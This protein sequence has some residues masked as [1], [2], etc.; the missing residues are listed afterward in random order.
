MNPLQL[1]KPQA[2]AQQPLGD[3][4]IMPEDN[5]CEPDAPESQLT[6]Q[7]VEALMFGDGPAAA[8]P[9]REL[10]ELDG[11]ALKYLA[12][13]LDDGHTFNPLFPFRLG[14]KYK[15][16]GKPKHQPDGGDL[17]SSEEN[18]IDA[19]MRGNRAKASA[20]LH[21]MKKLSGSAL[22]LVAQLLEDNPKLSSSVPYRL[23]FA[24]RRRGR[25]Y[26]PLRA[27]SFCRYLALANAKADMIR[28]GKKA[29]IEAAVASVTEKTG[30]SR[31]TVFRA[32][33]RHTLVAGNF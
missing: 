15:R 22:D 24:Y 23:V 29:K 13:L 33:R 14:F 25:P 20:A 27:K 2:V 1:P 16:Q 3:G 31:A 6:D 26:H 21:N 10:N 5:N 11:E 12:A 19:L 8:A 18:L 4:V 17:P 9:L 7:F 32:V 30:R 28:S